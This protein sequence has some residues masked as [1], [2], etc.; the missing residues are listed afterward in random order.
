MVVVVGLGIERGSSLPRGRI[1]LLRARHPEGVLLRG[2]GRVGGVW[3]AVLELE[4]ERG[5]IEFVE[6]MLDRGDGMWCCCNPL[7]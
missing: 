2:R 3:E 4:V 7:L 1:R 5:R 6:R